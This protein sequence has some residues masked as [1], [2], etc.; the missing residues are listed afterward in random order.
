MR[1]CLVALAYS[2]LATPLQA[3]PLTERQVDVLVR[4]AL[5]EW[6]VPGVAI[7]II[8]DQ[9]EYTQGYGVR[10]LGNDQA[11]TA[12][13]IF[14][15]SSCSKTLTATAMARLV[16]Q[17]KLRWDDPVRMHLPWFKLADPLA[18]AKV[19]VRDLLTHRTGLGKHEALWYR[20]SLSMEER[21]RRLA[22][23][24]PSFDFR[25]TFEYQ[26]MGYGT[27]GLAAGRAAGM[28][29]QELMKQAVFEPLEMK[30][31]SAVYP[32]PKAA[33]ASPH[34]K[35]ARGVRVVDRYPLDEPDPA[36]TIHSTARDLSNFLRLQLSLGVFK[37]RLVSEK[38]LGE[39]LSPQIVIPHSGF[40]RALNPHS[41]IQTYTLGWIAQDYRGVYVLLHGG[42]V[43]GF[44]AQ[45]TLVPQ[46]KLG[47]ALLNNLDRTW[48]NFAL[49]NTIV[50][51]C[52]QLPSRDWHA[53]CR[54]VDDENERHTNAA[55]QKLLAT[56]KPNTKPSAPLTAFEGKYFDQAYGACRILVEKGDRGQHQLRWD[57]GRV[58]SPLV[59]FQDDTFLL[60]QKPFDN[61]TLRFQVDSQGKVGA[62]TL[63]GRE[64]H[65]LP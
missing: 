14:P 38:T 20:T 54:R 19:T 49:T 58:G 63:M 52:L 18:N 13:T 32:G 17:G 47:I 36:G 42:T 45:L 37:E 48:M 35:T 2:T 11:V 9:F 40:S 28:S 22:F 12:D 46:A 41:N 25:T 24:D 33:C 10:E 31:T 51:R 34:F 62:L 44:R 23:L 60:V 59:H 53:H 56:K 57:W 1:F 26:A 43:D 61:M 30:N 21:A 64:F 39:V 29:W 4:E 5:K 50:D 7:A 3:Q 15:L 55:V 65:R 8:H 16:D 6:N 27:A